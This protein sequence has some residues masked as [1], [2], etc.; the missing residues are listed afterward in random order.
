MALV[1]NGQANTIGGLAVGGLPDGSIA[2]A[3]LAS[4]VGGKI[5]QVLQTTTTTQVSNTG[6]SYADTG[7]TGSIT[8]ASTSNKI[9][10]LVCQNY[11]QK[12]SAADAGGNI[13]LMRDST[14]LNEIIPNEN[15]GML[16][17]SSGVGGIS[18]Y[19]VYN[20]SYLD[21]PNTTS[22]ITYKTQCKGYFSDNNH[23]FKVNV[24][25]GKSFLTLIEVAG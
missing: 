21:S 10:V 25:S 6:T 24:G 16:I 3:D 1:L 8:P 23:A 13:N 11:E 14:Q 2:T 20:L 17:W 5:L 22:S 18:N 12:R 9:L 19:D 4:G 7:L 15:Y